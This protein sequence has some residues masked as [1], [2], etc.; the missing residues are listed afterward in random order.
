MYK[1]AY[2]QHGMT[3]IGWLIVLG[4][5]AFF[6]LLTLR[7]AP[8]YLEYYKVVEVIDSLPNEPNIGRKTPMEIR[9]LLGRRMDVNAITDITAKDIDIV[10]RSGRTTI[11]ADYEVRVPM[12]GNVDIVTK[13]NKSIEVVAN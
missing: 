4:L 6:V 7:L 9:S 12:L 5:I 13:F 8:G 2:R 1:F 3:G 11:T 10:Q